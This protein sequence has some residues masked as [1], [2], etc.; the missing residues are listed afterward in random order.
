MSQPRLLVLTST[1]PRWPGDTEPAFVEALSLELAGKFDVT[2]L[3]PHASGAARDET[4]QRDGREIRIRRFRYFIPGIE[5]LAYE[6]GIMARLK[7]NPLRLLLVPF[8]LLAGLI[9][10]ARLHYRFNFDV[11]HAHWLIPQ[12]LIASLLKDAPPYLVTA[13]GSDLYSLGSG[14]MMLLK[15]RAVRHAAKLTVVSDAMR[16]KAQALGPNRENIAVRSMG[17][18]LQSTFT[19]GSDEDR[20]G[21]AFVGRLVDVKGVPVLID[22]MAKLVSDHPD[23]RLTVIGDGPERHNIEER[24]AA[25][26]LQGNIDMAGSLPQDRIA[27]ALRGAR[28]LVMPSVVTASGAEEGFG[29]VAVEAMGCGCP[30]IA[31]NLAGIRDAV[32]DGDTG[33]VFES[34]DAKDLAEKIARLLGDEQLQARLARQARAYAVENFDWSVVGERYAELLLGTISRG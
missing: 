22:A 23:L 33:L 14:F 32:R 8:F 7:R 3:A 4:V 11:I 2:V 17:V 29:L 21:L 12:G 16:D 5:S 27:M 25:H 26:G 30:V 19:P 31:S 10:A 18:D 6:G 34:G 28:A 24:I 13:H 20:Q 15:R 9:A 1:L